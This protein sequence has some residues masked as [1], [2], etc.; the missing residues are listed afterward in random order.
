MVY[1]IVFTDRSVSPSAISLITDDRVFPDYK[2]EQGLQDSHQF[3]L[4]TLDADAIRTPGPRAR[5]PDRSFSVYYYGDP[6]PPP[7][8]DLKTEVLNGPWT[9]EK[10][11]YLV[12]RLNAGSVIIAPVR[13]NTPQQIKLL[14]LPPKSELSKAIRK[15][16]LEISEAQA[17]IDKATTTL[18]TINTNA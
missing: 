16:I 9:L 2:G 15:C 5:I 13:Q 17:M 3:V 4:S 7:G 10:C 14:A 11:T 8:T 1:S 18:D 12:R 6:L